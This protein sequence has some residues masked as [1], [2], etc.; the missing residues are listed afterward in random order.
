MVLNFCIDLT[1]GRGGNERPPHAPSWAEER[2]VYYQVGRV[3][4]KIAKK[5]EKLRE[6]KAEREAT[7]LRRVQLAR[8]CAM[9]GKVVVGEVKGVDSRA[10]SAQ[11]LQYVV[12]SISCARRPRG[13][14]SLRFRPGV[15]IPEVREPADSPDS[16]GGEDVEQPHEL[17]MD[18]P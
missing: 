11:S 14:I 7:T 17:A 1:R 4:K 18:P 3:P 16:G 2:D 8:S 15:I 5:V 9:G 10:G 6:A 13:A 12:S